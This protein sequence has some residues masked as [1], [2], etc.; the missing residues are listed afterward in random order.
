[1]TT[2]T[3]PTDQTHLTY[4]SGET[5][6]R[7]DCVIRITDTTETVQVVETLLP[8]G[9]CLVLKGDTAYYPGNFRLYA[10][11]T[12]RD[13][14]LY[15]GGERPKVGDVVCFLHSDLDVD[16]WVVIKVHVPA[17]QV[18]LS[19][20]ETLA[21]ASTGRC[22][23]IHRGLD[24]TDKEASLEA[25]DRLRVT[26]E[27]GAPISATDRAALHNLLGVAATSIMYTKSGSN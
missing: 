20:G 18:S 26:I 11:P 13:P 9:K 14:C 12:P 27:T 10:R 4:A 2:E 22:K 8:T 19:D 3:T 16:K 21:H 6:Q 17:D 1:M 15:V 7:G 24:L 5:P 23:L 25:C